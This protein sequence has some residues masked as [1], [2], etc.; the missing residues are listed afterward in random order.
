MLKENSMFFKQHS[1]VIACLICSTVLSSPLVAVAATV[2]DKKT[3]NVVTK[4]SPTKE[5]KQGNA[6]LA[7]P[8][9]M[10]ATAPT[11]EHIDVRGHMRDI[12]DGVTGRA[13][14]GGLMTP[15][16]APKSVSAITRDYIAKQNPALNPMQ[17]IR[18]LPGANVSNQD[19]L[20]MT[21]GHISV[22]GLTESQ[23]GFTLEG[24]PINDI[25][26]FAVYPQEIVD[27][28]NLSTVKL[29]QGSADLD[30]P[31][32]SSSGG[33]V[34]MYMIDPKKKMGGHVN[35]TYG[36]YNATRG[37]ARFDTGYIGNTNL[38]A[39]FS[40]SQGRQDHWRGPGYENKKHGE[41]KIVN[42]WGDGNRV[43]LAVVGNNLENNA[44]P[45][46]TKANWNQYGIGVDN[47]PGQKNPSGNTVYARYYTKGDTN[48]YKFRP[49]P[50]TN[51]YASM[52]S[53]FK[54]TDHLVLTET[55]YFWYGY[56]NGGGAQSNNANG[57]MTYGAQSN[58]TGLINGQVPTGALLYNPSL[59]ET[60]RP[61]ATTKLTWT[62]GSNR[63]MVGYWFEYSKQ[64]QTAPYSAISDDGT[65][66][67]MWGDSNNLI[68][69]NGVKAQ[70][71]D[72]LTQTQVH[73]PFI[74]DS[75]SLFHNK[76]TIDAGLKYA[77]VKRNGTN[78]LPDVDRKYVSTNYYQALPTAAIRY[79][80][81]QNHQIFASVATNFRMPQN[82]ALYD[83]G[84]YNST[85]KTK[86][87]GYNNKANPNQKSEISI[88][89]EAGW[90]YQ[91]DLISSS[92]TYF[93]YNFTNRLYQQTIINENGQ[94]YST[95]I[96]AG[97]AHS[98]GVDAEIGTRPIHHLRPYIS[99]E[100]LHAV[101]DSNLPAASGAD[102]VKTKGKAAPQAPAYQ[103][104][105]GLDYDD[106]HRF[107]GFDLKYVAKQYSTFMNDEHIP[108]YVLMNINVGYRFPKFG[109]FRS[110]TIRLNLQNISNNRYLDWVNASQ[111]NAKNTTGVFGSNVTGK[112]PTYTISSPFAA[113]ATISSDF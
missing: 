68:L 19:P 60:Y 49:N 1:S 53:T 26:N 34:D 46:V 24:F 18:L 37:F 25:G 85:D 50:F 41:M 104:G 29:A 72:T 33:V 102:Y 76:L 94:T 91:G 27:S 57:N 95:N 71:R 87:P 80:I 112:S 42:D 58:L 44:Y 20:G 65:P 55:P 22:R 111:V 103:V 64:R 101:T 90:R 88:S 78:Y 54:L 52:P 81:N 106:G 51:I 70:Y 67:N 107:A 9:M 7:A 23:M 113:I 66:L 62:A 108:G 40:Y 109:I 4:R 11:D 77:I 8:S 39:Y 96:N 83:S 86:A 61:G 45:S 56:G 17:L 105:F 38:R 73:T 16:D 84:S 28:E 2:T 32:I 3:S 110:P 63:L 69:S 10:G 15:T 48:Y 13:F 31:H 99:F 12:G 74:G 30:S 5:R 93:H 89:E 79:K 47:V 43:S 75:L 35:M 82:Y 92:I 98:D 36:S 21:G 14:G 6:A 100:Y 59:T 97:G